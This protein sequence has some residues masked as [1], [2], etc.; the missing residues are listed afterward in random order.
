MNLY[1]FSMKLV[2]VYVLV[3]KLVVF[4]MNKYQY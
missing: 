1:F 4:L 3:T 2:S